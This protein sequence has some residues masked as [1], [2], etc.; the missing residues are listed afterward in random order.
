M[1]PWFIKDAER[2]AP[3][4]VMRQGLKNQYNAE[5]I[6]VKTLVL[7]IGNLLLCDEGIGVHAAQALLE[8]EIPEDVTV[9]DIG[10]AILDALPSI[11]DADRIIVIDA[12]KADGPPGSI[13]RVPFEECAR[14]ECIASLHGFDLSRV[15]T[16]AGKEKIPK[17][18]VIGVEPA[19]IEWSMELS[20]TVKASL[21]LVLKAVGEEIKNAG[22]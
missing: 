4:G 12:M 6:R 21:P 3:K 16:L 10:T 13:Y 14:S 1:F 8:E 11:E 17:I 2:I 18:V 20:P 9:L 15:M 19:V 22:L 7:G 5:V